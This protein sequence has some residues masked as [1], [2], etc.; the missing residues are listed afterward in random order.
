[1]GKQRLGLGVQALGSEV[2]KK[3]GSQHSSPQALI[4]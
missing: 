2:G 3:P 1:M 4:S